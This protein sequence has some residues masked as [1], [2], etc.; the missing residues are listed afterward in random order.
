MLRRLSIATRLAL[1]A[2]LFLAP[3]GYG[4]W[5]QNDATAR[6]IAL[7]RLELTGAEYLR[8]IE[9]VQSAMARTAALREPVDSTALSHRLMELRER[10]GALL[11]TE[12]LSLEAEALVRSKDLTPTKSDSRRALRRLAQQVAGRSSI[13]LDAETASYALGDI[14]AIR[15]NDLRDLFVELRRIDRNATGDDEGR[16]V[17]GALLNGRIEILLEAVDDAMATATGPNGAPWLKATLD[18]T[19]VPFSLMMGHATAMVETGTGDAAL[20][21]GTFDSIDRFGASANARFVELLEGRITRLQD[22]RLRVFAIGGL[23]S[24][25]AF[26]AVVALVRAGVIGPLR[27]MTDALGR[28]ADGDTTV[29]VPTTRFDDEVA[30]LG[31]A[32]LRFKRALEESGALSRTVVDSTVQVSVATREAAAAVGQ[33]SD[34]ALGQMASLDRLRQSFLDTQEAMRAVV[35][36]THTGQDHSRSSA[37][38][39]EEGLNDMAAMTAAVREIADL[40]TE[41]NRVTA[42]IGKLATHSNILSLNA[43]IEA[44]RAGEHG[45]GFSVVAGA[46]GSLAQQTLALAQE[47]AAL[48]QRSHE[49]IARGLDMAAAVGRRM[50][51]VSA[52]IAETDRLSQTIVD[53]VARQR[54]TMD[55]IE[56]ALTDLAVISHTNA[57]AAEQIAATMSS[58]AAL[59]EVTRERAEA[60]AGGPAG[61]PDPA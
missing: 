37:L 54:H 10:Y 53:E 15:L 23:L 9:A 11:E 16:R 18:E 8:G 31:A 39:L 17:D 33:V 13:I 51:Q 36:V 1:A 34:G 22:E 52:S 40:S 49:R 45:R 61:S 44:S 2:S 47:I 6:T 19:F 32:M 3:V 29:A 57:S 26:A 59:T 50:E 21:R 24:L 7:A 12:A 25:V 20:V 38:R 48:A 30:A 14:F 4:L 28:L 60:V 5:I 35:A 43:S 58:L 46:V 56:T 55:G 27:R 42:A 41:I